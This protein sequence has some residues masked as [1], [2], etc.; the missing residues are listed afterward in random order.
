MQPIRPVEVKRPIPHNNIG[1][2]EQAIRAYAWIHVSEE[3]RHISRTL[4]RMTIKD[5]V[6]SPDAL[7]SVVKRLVKE[8]IHLLNIVEDND[9]KA[10]L[11]HIIVYDGLGLAFGPGTSFSSYLSAT[12]ECLYTAAQ[13]QELERI[14]IEAIANVGAVNMYKLTGD[15]LD[16]LF[17]M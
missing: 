16:E 14:T 4:T 1:R 8:D 10:F 15:L 7:E 13:L 9:Y 3:Y 11:A 12:G 17:L 5:E 6:V 2:L